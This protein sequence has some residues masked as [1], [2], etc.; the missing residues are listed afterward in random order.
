MIRELV[1]IAVT[2]PPEVR[3]KYLAELVLAVALIAK[4]ISSGRDAGA[5]RRRFQRRR[6]SVDERPPSAR[7]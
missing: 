2:L 7:T 1:R 4:L 5:C 6:W 3:A